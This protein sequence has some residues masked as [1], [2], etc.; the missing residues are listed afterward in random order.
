MSLLLK[1]APKTLDDV[2][3]H[4]LTA[5]K[6]R[7]MVDNGVLPNM[8]FVGPCGTGKT[9]TAACLAA[10][11]VSDRL[12][13]ILQLN[14]CDNRGIEYIGGALSSFCKKK[15]TGLKLVILDEA[16]NMTTKAQNMA[17]NIMDASLQSTRFIITCNDLKDISDSMQSRTMIVVFNNIP[18]P[19][20]LALLQRICQS[21]QATYEQA[22]LEQIYQSAQGD[23]RK[24]IQMLQLVIV[25]ATSVTSANVTK[26]CHVPQPCML[27]PCI[28]HCV[29]E[30]LPAALTEVR[31]L[32]ARGFTTSDIL[33]MLVT[34]LKDISIDE[35]IRVA[36]VGI[37]NV[38]L[39]TSMNAECEVVQLYGCLAR[40]IKYVRSAAA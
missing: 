9:V 36:F 34:L 19:T 15:A 26:Y 13:N 1:Y 16:D 14:A 30:N 38:T 32:I 11:F 35:D 8:I 3:A 17:A 12:N 7:T 40:M 5:A 28:Q 21:E 18:R 39:I 24:C 22:A 37:I 4:P 20:V 33:I 25:A 6:F 10:Q 2:I 27:L 23:V 31:S 29:D